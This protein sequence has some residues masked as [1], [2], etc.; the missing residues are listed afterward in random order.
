MKVALIVGHYVYGKDKGAVSYT[1]E[2]ESHY[3]KRIALTLQQSL[4][5][6]DVE[7]KIFTRDE[8]RTFA[9]IAAGIKGF[10]AQLSMEMHFNSFAT[11]SLGC[12]CLAM[13]KDQDSISFADLVTDKIAEIVGVTERG[14]GGPS[15]FNAKSDGV[16]LIDKGG[17]GF[18]NL[19]IV[20]GINKTIPVVLVEPC[21]ANIK[22]EQ[23]RKFFESEYLYVQALEAAILEWLHFD[24]SKTIDVANIAVSPKNTVEAIMNAVKR[25]YK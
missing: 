25:D 12:E 9:N 21:F 1:G 2:T 3:N 15:K 5:A 17:R 13:V 7:V 19:N 11:A 24:C 10:G 8:Y 14:T 18:N 22:T 16:L 23:S 4:K 20:K 6:H